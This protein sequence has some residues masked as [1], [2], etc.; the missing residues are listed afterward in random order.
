MNTGAAGNTWRPGASRHAVEARADLLR[1]IRTFFSDRNVL[2][3]ETPLLS[4]AGN[5]DPNIQSLTIGSPPRKFLRTSPE[6]AMKRLLA[7]GFRDIYELGRVFRAGEAGRHHNPEFTMLEW[8]R[9][10]WDYHALMDEVA[11]LV[12]ASCAGCEI[13]EQRTSYRDLFRSMAGIDPF[14]AGTAELAQFA[15]SRNI[16][17][18]DLD[19]GQWLDLIISHVIQPRLPDETMTFVF[20]YP[21][22]Q[23]ALARIRPDEPPVAERFELFLG[24]VELANGYQELTDAAEQRERFIRENRS[25][26]SSGAN[27]CPLD[28][29]LLDALAH[30]MPECSG[31]AL[32]FDR[33]LMYVVRAASLDEVIPFPADRA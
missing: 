29:H 26:K 27:E 13:A 17:A 22:G 3:V 32:G 14:A 19:H 8:Y 4:R 10:G 23:A 28:E 15:K 21:A 9:T 11:E 12:K 20:D 7:A 33:L 25:R 1:N 30:G 16:D 2:E 18:P 5:S 6:Y 31:V 24:Q